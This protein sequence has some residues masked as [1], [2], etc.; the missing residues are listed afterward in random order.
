MSQMQDFAS[1]QN[2]SYSVM[3][4]CG[5]KNMGA[6]AQRRIIMS[7]MNPVFV[8][9]RRHPD[10]YR[11]RDDFE[12]VLLDENLKKMLSPNHCQKGQNG[13]FCD[14]SV[15]FLKTRQYQDDDIFTVRGVE[16]YTGREV[17]A[18]DNDIFLVP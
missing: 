1:P 18:D 6:S 14:G 8:R 3:L 17:P 10:L 12:K 11:N 9:F 5:R 4:V 2:V 13:L 15:E 16:E 7:D